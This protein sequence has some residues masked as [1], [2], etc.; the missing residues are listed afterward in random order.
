[1]KFKGYFETTTLLQFAYFRLGESHPVTA[2]DTKAVSIVY[3]EHIEPLTKA[4][5]VVLVFV[6][7]EVIAKLSR[8]EYKSCWQS[9]YCTLFILL[10]R[11]I[12][13]RCQVVIQET[14]KSF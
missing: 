12:I 2:G 1:M 8:I 4:N 5:P 10:I 13:A 6:Q 7:D 11:V 9:R 14:S 3:K